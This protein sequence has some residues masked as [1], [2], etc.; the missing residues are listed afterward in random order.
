MKARYFCIILVMVQGCKTE[1][2]SEQPPPAAGCAALDAGLQT[3]MSVEG[4]VLPSAYVFGQT[5]WDDAGQLNSFDG[6]SL[7]LP[8]EEEWSYILFYQ[9]A[10]GVYTPASLS[11]TISYLEPTYT[12]VGCEIELSLDAG[13]ARWIDCELQFDPNAGTAELSFAETSMDADASW[14]S[15][16]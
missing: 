15:E 10:A 7:E 6:P 5:C 9:E 14:M 16:N 11:G 8:I 1:V 12:V 13:R 3:N 2:V 4:H